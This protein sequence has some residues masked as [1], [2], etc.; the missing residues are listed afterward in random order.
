MMSKKMTHFAY[1]IREYIQHPSLKN[2]YGMQDSFLCLLQTFSKCHDTLWSI[3]FQW[4]Q[5]TK[6]KKKLRNCHCTTIGIIIG[7]NDSGFL[8]ADTFCAK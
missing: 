6:N 3:H 7:C 2:I 5:G 4:S 1:Y 8:A